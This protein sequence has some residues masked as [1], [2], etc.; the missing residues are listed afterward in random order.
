MSLVLWIKKQTQLSASKIWCFLHPALTIMSFLIFFFSF[1]CASFPF[2]D[3]DQPA[4]MHPDPQNCFLAW[5]VQNPQRALSDDY[6]DVCPH[7]YAFFSSIGKGKKKPA[8]GCRCG[9]ATQFP[10]TCTSYFCTEICSYTQSCLEILGIYPF[11]LLGKLTCCGQRCPC[12]VD[13][14][15]MCTNL[16]FFAFLELTF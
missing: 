7:L 13:R 3:L 8:V 6:W 14:W 11:L 2:P 15:V 5:V 16:F 1:L 9:N 12:Y 10:G 4:H